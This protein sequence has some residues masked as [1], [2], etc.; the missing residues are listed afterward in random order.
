M[1]KAVAGIAPAAPEPYRRADGVGGQI[2]AAPRR[3]I[4]Q[5]ICP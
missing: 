3:A 5:E 2:S 4:D 1:A